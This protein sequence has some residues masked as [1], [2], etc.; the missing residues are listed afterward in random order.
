MAINVS[1]TPRV[2]TNRGLIYSRA[3]IVASVLVAIGMGIN[4]LT[5]D[6][7]GIIADV[8]LVLTTLVIAYLIKPND[9]LASV[10]AP[11]ISWFV[12]LITVGQFAT[13]STGSFKV[14][15]VFLLVYGLGAHAFWIVGCSVLAVAIHFLR[16]IRK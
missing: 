5:R 13:R 10:W 2:A 16:E 3:I 1:E 15:Q 7:I 8:T 12:A 11:S 14:K 4:I 9:W 6:N